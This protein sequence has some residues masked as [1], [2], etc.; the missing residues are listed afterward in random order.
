MFPEAR[1]RIYTSVLHSNDNTIGGYI[2]LV[3]III[4]IPKG[5][6]TTERQELISRELSLC[7]IHLYILQAVL[8]NGIW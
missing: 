1:G 2:F 5:N 4:M 7:C 8:V 3:L 6:T